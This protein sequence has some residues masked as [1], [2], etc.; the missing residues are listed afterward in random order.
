MSTQTHHSSTKAEQ[1]KTMAQARITLGEAKQ[2]EQAYRQA[3]LSAQW[4]YHHA[5]KT[6]PQGARTEDYRKLHAHAVAQWTAAIEKVRQA[7]RGIR[8][9]QGYETRL[10]YMTRKRAAREGL[11]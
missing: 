6:D 3:A 4:T 8:S 7:R 9:A 2:V 1:P 11:L 10:P 5:V